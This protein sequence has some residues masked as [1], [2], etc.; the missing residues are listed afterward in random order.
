VLEERLG[1]GGMG[2]VHRAH[3]ALLRRPTA[4]KLLPPDRVGAQALARFEREV[5]QTARLAHPSTVQIYDYGRTPDGVFYY[6]MELLS[7]ADLEIVVDVTGPMPPARVIHVV[8]QVCGSLDEAHR[9]GLVHRDIKPANVIL[10][11]RAGEHDVAKVVDFG[12][13]REIR[14]EST[15]ALTADA[16]I[17]GTPLYLAPETISGAPAGPAADL[18]SL[19]AVAYFLLTATHVFRRASVVEI[20]A[21]HLHTAPEP[22]SAR[23]GALPRVLEAVVLRCLAKRPEERPES[24]AA[25]RD[26]LL[27]CGV[28]PWTER[29]ASAWWARHGEAIERERASRAS[30]TVGAPG[31]TLAIDLARRS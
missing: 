9:L 18:Y 16:V 27:G 22:P 28:E 15:P 19:G 7:G 30:G 5:R 12:L 23:V 3:H 17:T 11:E 8:A 21:D 29:D 20:C 2:V 26:A 6:A 13:V 14:A 25:L 24:A 4:I 1:A 10:T 31:R